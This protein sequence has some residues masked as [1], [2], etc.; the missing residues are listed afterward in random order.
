MA[1]LIGCAISSLTRDT[2]LFGRL[3]SAVLMVRFTIAIIALQILQI[4]LWAELRPALGNKP[5]A[6]LVHNNLQMG[7]FSANESAV[8]HSKQMKV[9]EYEQGR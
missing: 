1:A 7:S 9:C 6:P 2:N 8:N 3:R 5:G 4:F